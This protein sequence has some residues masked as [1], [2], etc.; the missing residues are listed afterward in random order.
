M[1]VVCK[2]TKCICNYCTNLSVPEK[3]QKRQLALSSQMISALPGSAYCTCPYPDEPP[4]L[5]YDDFEFKTS[6]PQGTA[7]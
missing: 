7:V 2:I 6:S 1:T 3:K 5:A 4:N